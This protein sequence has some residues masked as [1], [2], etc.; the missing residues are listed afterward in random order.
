MA[1]SR[2]WLSVLYFPKTACLFSHS[3]LIGQNRIRI[4]ENQLAPLNVIVL[5]T[6][7]YFPESG[8]S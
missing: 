8:R 1:F 2:L 3:Q 4:A 5:Q 6:A 7:K